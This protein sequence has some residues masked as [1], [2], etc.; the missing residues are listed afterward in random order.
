MI[1]AWLRIVECATVGCTSTAHLRSYHDGVVDE[2][3]KLTA[4]ARAGLGW[5]VVKG[6]SFCPRHAEKLRVSLLE[7]PKGEDAEAIRWGITERCHLQ[8]IDVRP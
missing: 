4:T 1:P 5:L 6:Y 2:R 3:R 8:R 7:R